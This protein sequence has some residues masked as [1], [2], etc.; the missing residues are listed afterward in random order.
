MMPA[1]LTVIPP[2]QRGDLVRPD[3][4]RYVVE[5]PTGLL[6]AEDTPRPVWDQVTT[7]LIRLHKRVEWALADAINFGEK[8]YGTKY[9]E[10]VARTGL[11]RQTLMNIASVGRHFE[12]SR[13]REDVSFSLHAEVVALPPAE[14][15]TLLDR[16]RAEGLSSRDVREQAA[17]IKR[18]IRSAPP[19]TGTVPVTA[20]PGVVLAIAD[21]RHL[22]LRDASVHLVVTSPPYN[23]GIAYDV[24][25]DALSW[26]DYWDGLIVPAL[27]EAFRVLAH[28][29][30]LCLNLA[31][32]VRDA[33][34]APWPRLVPGRIWPLLEQLGFLPREQL[35]WIKGADPANIPTN[36]TAWGTFASAR[37][38]VL[39]ATVEPIFIA[40]KGT[41]AREPGV[42]D[43]TSEE[44]KAWCR[45]AWFI[46][47]GH[48]DGSHPATFPLEL[49]RR[50]IKLYS[51]VGDV[52]ADPFAG[53]G[54]TAR[55]AHELGRRSFACDLSER[56]VASARRRLA[57]A[58]T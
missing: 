50:L 44:Y 49:P 3:E 51:Y 43:L 11:A 55:A 33:G 38:P 12:V 52:V 19:V 16:S 46:E 34:P 30:R 27:R 4:A 8:R 2:E 28:G 9:P 35:T 15:D 5:T 56:Y 48:G 29:G 10:W 18:V 32:V 23:G 40:S 37:N 45:N 36:S 17:Q 13:R 58:G 26:D 1:A 47:A 7:R 31:N 41:H 21:A 57:A 54:T 39:R 25:N 6:F 20:P 24:H 22:P 14:A 42:S 53:S